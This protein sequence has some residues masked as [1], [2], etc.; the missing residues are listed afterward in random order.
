VNDMLT[1]HAHSVGLL[2]ILKAMDNFT[3]D[4]KINAHLVLNTFL[5][6]KELRKS[7]LDM[8]NTI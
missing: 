6:H 4:N 2:H 3:L 8:I 1:W 7:T 5:N